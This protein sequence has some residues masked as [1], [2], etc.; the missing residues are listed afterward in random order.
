MKTDFF[1][2]GSPR[3]LSRYLNGFQNGSPRH[4]ASWK[5]VLN[6]VLNHKCLENFHKR[7][8]RF[9]SC[10]GRWGST[11]C[12]PLKSLRVTE[13]RLKHNFCR[14]AHNRPARML[15]HL[16]HIAINCG[17]TPARNRSPAM[18]AR[19]ACGDTKST[20]RCTAPS[21]NGNALSRVS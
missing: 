3:Y 18:P 8:E 12:S 5:T 11:Q 16:R 4:L 14:S 13:V 1:Q 15:H 20:M 7:L 10:D 6:G 2:D 17:A 21:C 9:C 19:K